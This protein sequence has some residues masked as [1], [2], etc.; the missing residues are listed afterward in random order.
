MNLVRCTV[1]AVMFVGAVCGFL[2]AP[3]QAASSTPPLE[4]QDAIT[5]RSFQTQGVIVALSPDGRWVVTTVCDQTEVVVGDD[6]DGNISTEGAA[7]RSVGCDLWLYSSRDGTRRNLTQDDGNNWSPAW[8]PD[9]K[10][11][12]FYSDRDGQPNLWLW[13]RDA[14]SFRKVSDVRTRNWL[15]YQ[16]PSWTPDGRKLVVR[17]PPER[18]D[19]DQVGD[20]NAAEQTQIDDREPGSTVTVFVS[21]RPAPDKSEQANT[22]AANGILATDL[23]VIDVQ[24]GEVQRL[25]RG[26]QM[27]GSYKLSPDGRYLV[28]LDLNPAAPNRASALLLMELSTGTS[29]VL[30]PNVVQSFP[31][32]MSWSP[33]GRRLAYTAIDTEKRKLRVMSSSDTSLSTMGGG[34]LFILA[35]DGGAPQRVTG[36]PDNHFGVDLLPPLWDERGERLYLLGTDHQIWKVDVAAKRAQQLTTDTE[37]TKHIIVGN[38][39]TVAATGNARYLHVLTRN[40]KNRRNGFS[41]VDLST[42]QSTLL[43]EEAK[44]YG[45]TFAVPVMTPDRRHIVYAAQ[46]SHESADLWMADVE[47]R[48]PRRLTTIN[49][50]L[51]KY[52]FGRSQLIEF[53]SSDGKPLRA[54][55][56]LP[57]DY[58]PGKRYPMVVWVYASNDDATR[59]V[60]HFGLVGMQAFNMHMFTTRGYAV[61]WPDIPTSE[62]AVIKDLMK[63]VMPA[64]DRVVHL[65]IADP[66]RLAVMGNS[67]GG[68]S[69][70]A[71]ITQTKRFKAAVMNSGFGDLTAFYGTMGGGWIPWLERVGG[72]MRVPPWEAPMR[73]VENSPFYYLDR[74]ETP[75][76]IQ[77]GTA[78]GGIIKH[79]D[80]VWVGMQRLNKEAIYLRYGGEAHV[81]AAAANLKDYWKRV[82]AFFDQHL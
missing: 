62:G 52:T 73:Y 37:R 38:G 43:R 66:D 4:I 59:N 64:I 27:T 82:L 31:G 78:D 79:S 80:Q 3:A 70:L 69:T 75:L 32:A 41:R 18:L 65:G 48:K 71:L 57:A 22:P 76:I 67:N 77:A 12:A 21:P 20:S 2:N 50:Q 26:L 45:T 25:A 36:A 44:V 35:V 54:A 81:L 47:F 14:D 68:Y 42:G 40:T 53:N 19:P 61:M 29:R 46:G 1:S 8:S 51:E 10:R 72:S 15:A 55:V 30:V 58:Q 6:D 7:Y 24:S 17:L 9:G 5:A 33:D 16:A 39:N 34:D 49:P 11:L 23:G 60:N 63:A 28:Y 13:A 74:I 56:L